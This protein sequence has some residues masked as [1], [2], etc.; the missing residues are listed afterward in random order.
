MM[1]MM[2]GIVHLVQYAYMLPCRGRWG[3]NRW[4]PIGNV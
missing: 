1:V 2:M 3:P 4:L